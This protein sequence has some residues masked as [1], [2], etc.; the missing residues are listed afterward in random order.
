MWEDPIVKEVREIRETHAAR[1]NYDLQ[2]I[3]ND[4]KKQEKIS[5]RKFVSFKPRACK[6]IK[7]AA[8]IG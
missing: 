2:A 6:P 5:G 4:L 3:Y 8:S 7:Q 1:F